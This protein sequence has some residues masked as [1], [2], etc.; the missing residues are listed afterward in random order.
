VQAA[1]ALVATAVIVTSIVV[2][3]ITAYWCN[4]FNKKSPEHIAAGK[5]TA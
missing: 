1:T 5:V 4:H 3:I 2:P